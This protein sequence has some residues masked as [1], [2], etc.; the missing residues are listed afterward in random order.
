MDGVLERID[1]DEEQKTDG[2]V[3]TEGD[4]A[5]G[6]VQAEMHQSSNEKDQ[7]PIQAPAEGEEDDDEEAG[8]LV[9]DGLTPNVPL[10]K[11]EELMEENEDLQNTVDAQVKSQL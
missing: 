7:P 9:G 3:L 10:R 2:S 8:T 5:E 1:E 11:S 6:A 4:E